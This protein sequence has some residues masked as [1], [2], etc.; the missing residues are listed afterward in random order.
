MNLLPLLH[1]SMQH[2]WGVVAPY[3]P[4]IALIFVARWI[5]Q[6]R[7]LKGK[8]GEFK[9]NRILQKCLGG[10]QYRLIKNV[11]LSLE[12]DTTQVDHILVSVFGVFVIETKNMGGWIFGKPKEEKWTQKFRWKKGDQFQNPR[13]QNYKHVQAVRTLCNLEENQVHSVV[14]FVGSGCFKRGMPDDDVVYG[15]DLIGRIKSY[16]EEVLSLSE[17]GGVVDKIN[18]VR[19][20]RSMKTDRR[21]RKHVKD[22]MR[23]RHGGAQVQEK[24]K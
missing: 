8:F 15:R 5:L 11:T 7:W 12:E 19:L 17:V 18:D 3:L 16:N 24:G 6:S 9:V 4:F 20:S 13:R 21:H 1:Q 2:L 22:K 10:E 14:V 23:R